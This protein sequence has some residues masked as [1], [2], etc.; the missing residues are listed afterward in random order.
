MTAPPLAGPLAGLRV[1]ELE[2]I[3]PVPY[4]AMLLADL[5]ADV[6]T[7]NRP[8]A[9]LRGKRVSGRSRR[10]VE[11]DLKTPEGLAA[12]R[13]LAARAD[14]LL[15]GFRPGVLERLG[16]APDDLLAAAPGL[17]VGRMTGWGQDGPLAPAAGHDI[18]YIALTGAL[19][20][21]GPAG[22]DPVPPLNLV[23]DFAGGAL[24]LVV[25]VLA[26][27]QERQRSGRGQ[28]VDAAM[29]DGASHLMAMFWSLRAEGLWTNR[30]GANMLDGGAPYYGTYRCACGG[31]VAIGPIEP[32]F[33]AEFVAG[34]GVDPVLAARRDDP[35]A[36]PALRAEIAARIGARRRDDW[37]AVFAGSD[38]C[39]APV[40]ALDEVPAH[41]HM[42]ARGVIVEHDGALQ[43]APAPRFSRS[44]PAAPR[45]PETVAPAA[46]LAGWGG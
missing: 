17:V 16:L 18:T 41:P 12:V 1:I 19:A 36:W 34:A 29:V 45:S 22:G 15:E 6:V 8:G 27:L 35:A 28:V 2:A 46:V 31:H 38:A 42:A 4:A 32:K 10:V 3:G 23:G 44:T 9:D 40:L 20:A 11:L 33:W 14:V 5:G 37:A 7:V 43:P 30:R 24:F 26:A 25:G 13:R 39:V 21:I